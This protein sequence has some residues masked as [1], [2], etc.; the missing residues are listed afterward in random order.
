MVDCC[1]I[2]PADITV[3]G[4]PLTELPKDLYIPPDALRILLDTF[5][6]PLDLLLYLIKK[7]H[8]DILDI[9][10]AEITKQYMQF[11]ALMQVMNIEWVA[12]YLVMAATLIE[13][14][15]RLL[16]PRPPAAEG[17]EA[18]DPRAD[19]VQRLQEYE[20]YKQAALDLDKQTLMERDTYVARANTVV[21][22]P[23]RVHANVTVTQ[24]IDALRHI[25]ERASLKEQYAVI[26]EPLSIR[27]RMAMILSRTNDGQQIFFTQLFTR[28]EGKIG[29]VVTL[30]AILELIR[31]SVIDIIQEEPF[32]PIYI[33]SKASE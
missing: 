5:E 24:L 17:E 11:M 19:L 31:Q 22:E 18:A 16:L 13:I 20:R 15:S 3:A 8:I 6:G 30:I 2:L 14:K 25:F 29:V 28:A 4:Q 12:E 1:P 33:C 32:A 26:R 21:M 23:V 10:V 27:E 7:Q 9:P